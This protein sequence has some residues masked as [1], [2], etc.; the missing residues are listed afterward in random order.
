MKFNDVKTL[1]HLLKEYGMKP[2][3][4]LP[5]SPSDLGFSGKK[6]GSI[7]NKIPN[8]PSTSTPNSVATTKKVAS[9]PKQN[10][11]MF[12]NAKLQKAKSI[13]KVD[14]ETIIYD[15]DQQEIG[16]VV[17][18]VGTN[19]QNKF[20]VVQKG[21]DKPT[22][23][24]PD[25]DVLIPEGKLGSRLKKK[26]KKLSLRGI[27]NKI[28]KLSKKRLKEAKPE[29]FEINYNKKEIARE[30]LDL[31]IRCGFEAE[32]FWY[33]G[34]EESRYDI[35]DM[36]LDEVDS[37][38]GLPDSAY[39]DYEEHVRERAWDE[40]YISDLVDNWIEENRDED[41]FIDD[42]MSQM[43]P[44]EDAVLDYIED[45]RENDPKEYNNR[46]EDGWDL[47][48]WK[49]DFINEEYEQEYEDF[50][51]DIGNEEES[52]IDDGIESCRDDYSMD[53]W[54]SDQ[55]YSMSGFLDDYGWD[56]Q[57]GGDGGVDSVASIFNNWQEVNS[58]FTDYPETGE[59]GDTSGSTTNWAVET[60]ST[61]EADSG[62]GAEIISPVY[63]TPR[64][65]LKE[66]KSLFEYGED[67][68]GTNRSTGL[69]FTMSWYGDGAEDTTRAISDT[70]TSGPNKLKMAL[71]L[72]DEYLLDQFDRLRNT[73]T[74]SQYQNVLKH[75]ENIKRGDTNSFEKLEAELTKG[76]SDAKYSSI[77]FK[78]SYAKD[79]QSGNQL[80]EFRIAGGDDYE[81]DFEKVFSAVVRYATVMKAGYDKDSYRIEYIRAMSRVIRKSSEV[82]PKRAKEFDNINAPVLD[83]AKEIV[84]KKEYFDVLQLLQTSLEYLESFKKLNEP[85]A[86]KKW[87]QSIKD[88]KK[89]TGSDP[90]WMG[91]AEESESIPGYIEPD[92]VMPSKRAKV[93][94]Q[95]A[96][97]SFGKAVAILSKNIHDKTARNNPRAKDI[98]IFRKY[99]KELGMDSKELESLLV[100]SM[101]N[102]NYN[103]TD[104]ENVKTLQNGSSLLFKQDLISTPD[105]LTRQDYDIIADAMWQF[106]QTDDSKDNRKIDELANILMKVNP[107]NDK[108][109]VVDSLKEISQKRQKNDVF[110]YLRDGPYGISASLLKPG[111]I[112][113]SDAINE[114]M[115]FL[116]PYEGYDHP[117]GRDHHVNVKSDD[118]YE[119]V[120]QMNMI[121]KMRLRLDH[122]K[123]IKNT[124]VEKYNE[125]HKKL[126]KIGYDFL[127]ALKPVEFDDA[128][129]DQS[130]LG[131]RNANIRYW[132][133]TLD[134]YV[135]NA[136][137]ENDV[138]NFPSYFDDAVMS[139]ISLDNYFYALENNP[140]SFVKDE[141]K[142][143]V[144]ERFKAI[145]KLLTDF[146]KLF[147]A[148]GFAN[149]K[150]E[151]AGKNKLDK[152]NKDFEKNVRNNA[153]AKIN[154]PSHSF[155]YLKNRF[156]QELKDYPNAPELKRYF[157]DVNMGRDIFVIPAAHW[158]QA[159]D[160]IN[161]LDIIGNFE[162]ANNY[163][164][165]WRKTP[166]NRI[167]SQ[168]YKTYTVTFKDLTNKDIFTSAGSEEYTLIKDAN[169][170]ITRIGDSRAGEPGQTYLVDPDSVKNPNSDEPLNRTSAITWSMNTDN[171]EVARFKAF[172]FS[173]YPKEMKQLVAKEMKL[174]DEPS[175]KVSLENVLKKIV[176]GDIKLALNYQD[177]KQGMIKAAGVEDYKDASSNEVAG[178]T[179]WGN[180]TDYLKL[181]RGVNDQA[182]N[183]LRKVYDQFDS[184]HNWRPEGDERAVGTERWAEAVKAA[185]NYIQKNY[186]VSGGN[187]F[188]DGDDVSD[189]YSTDRAS[190]PTTSQLSS[191]S[192][193]VTTQDYSDMRR[194]YFNFNS[195]MMNGMQDYIV[196]SDVNSLVSF[197]KNPDNDETF[198]KAVLQSMMREREGGAEPNDFQGHLAR[199]R[200]FLQSQQTDEGVLQRFE[201]LP[202]EEQ[203]RIVNESEVL[204]KWSKKYKASINCS[205][206]KGFSQKAHCAGKK[207]KAKEGKDTPCPACG[208]PKCDHKD[209]HLKESISEGPSSQGLPDN[210]IPGILNKI[211]ADEFPAWDLKKQFLAYYAI[212]DPAM[213]SD[214]RARRAEQGPNA[215]LRSIVRFYAQKQLDPRVFKQIDLNETSKSK[216]KTIINEA[217]GLYGRN[218]GDKFKKDNVEIEFQSVINYPERGKFEDDEKRDEQIEKIKQQTGSDI[219][220]VNL[221]NKG[222]LAFAIATLT[223]TET[224]Q[225]VVWGRYFREIT[226]QMLGKWSNKE[227]PMGWKLQHNT[228]LKMEAGLDPQHLIATGKWI[229]GTKEVISLIEQNGGDNPVVPK[230]V[231][232]LEEL[233]NGTMPMFNDE[234]TQLPAIRDY[235]GEIMGPVAFRGGLD[236]NGQSET[237]RNELLDGASWNECQIRWPQEMNYAL[238]DSIFKGPNGAEV[239]ISS[240]GGPGGGASAGI[241][242]IAKAMERANDEL[243]QSHKKAV[244]IIKIINDNT[245][246]NGPFR[247]AEYFGFLPK[248]LEEEIKS[249]TNEVKKD[250]KGISK[251][252][253][254][255]ISG[256]YGEL[257]N[258]EEVAGFNTG[259]AL[260]SKLAVKICKHINN[261]V[262]EFS[263]GCLAFL[264]QSAI[265]QL[266]LKMGVKGQDTFVSE[267]RSVYPPQFGGRIL[268]DSGKTYYSSRI[269]SK[270]TFKFS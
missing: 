121:Q 146:D 73:F 68:F 188:R 71:L 249:Y 144:K 209:E 95:R 29:L 5:T 101:D 58:K 193:E 60:D 31:P 223:N 191:R 254:E 174:M 129:D 10:D 6:S 32:T 233:S 82:D 100:T 113:N 53:E 161:G 88:F 109:R 91:E 118:R 208:D 72:G 4:N 217:R 84:S 251:G 41:E 50:L 172:D 219:E 63:E 163:F 214:F 132:N 64:E 99:A 128:Y 138:Y 269:G 203:L 56:Y 123:E 259:F 153:V 38:Y 189:V 137:P 55:F 248:G 80:I 131:M 156:I 114:L 8:S 83:S 92:R 87:K 134:A 186:T 23:I 7:V 147:Q 51:R 28:K 242:N 107:K 66:V 140:E 119:M 122:L 133:D 9:D 228:A 212:P 152:R 3:K 105:F 22:V 159:D 124:D 93:S 243:L 117:T 42:F 125:I 108:E 62:A 257:R 264:N 164:H 33:G 226:P 24:D 195:M 158:T 79:K 258:P 143:V 225:N 237:A 200:V 256:T 210:S 59:Y 13:Q 267:W 262:P 149:L 198:K 194:K 54:V 14:P 76:I 15:K 35:D 179:N 49:R 168:F 65:M 196:Q 43:G 46:E 245:A 238:V 126:Y 192:S 260:M 102:A 218:A 115:D 44:T 252:A 151:I 170:E 21:N 227:V 204:E 67:E 190:G 268:L 111:S 69:H 52:V 250:F 185:Y 234:R 246:L 261:N 207:K 104:S 202:L 240:K 232:A 18:P 244:E 215:C 135:K 96:K 162:S 127:N 142:Q 139:Q 89:D 103:D 141:V 81:R 221:S 231:N 180:L 199:G 247:L 176:D 19:P 36:T 266:Y 57:R 181:E 206:P 136:D 61:I 40:G 85:D 148:E 255:L 39:E 205:N 47:D 178:A 154:I 239:G 34:E 98:G 167:L 197:L 116:E 241:S 16:T 26:N 211:L 37:E 224:G 48:N 220:W 236:S 97:E 265:I 263:T 216:V 183:L 106:F 201:N 177:N 145:K 27:K 235:F 270:F 182:I 229:S 90:S 173:I 130:Y 94:L 213:L 45:F 160:A 17:A 75:A 187:Y 120:Y 165:S 175:F 70:E 78:D 86:D 184:N 12:T 155:V 166:Y 230:L 169:V 30:A 171:S 1:K 25:Q 2:G 110:R 77:H 157:D 222:T 11:D 253:Q 74:K 20:L 150:K 112:S